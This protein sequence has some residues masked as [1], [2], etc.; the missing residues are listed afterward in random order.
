M[1]MKVVEDEENVNVWDEG[2][3]NGDDVVGV[4]VYGGEI[5]YFE[6]TAYEAY[7]ETARGGAAAY[8]EEM[9]EGDD[10]VNV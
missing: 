6:C 5:F 4:N 2:V 8:E 3:V 9:V 10:D 7:G 1:M